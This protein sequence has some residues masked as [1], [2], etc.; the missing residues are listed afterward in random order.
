LL[1]SFQKL[2]YYSNLFA[3]KKDKK[4]T[5]KTSKDS[6]PSIWGKKN[7]TNEHMKLNQDLAAS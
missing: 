4:K 5:L 1:T 3:R 2:N 7:T 6:S